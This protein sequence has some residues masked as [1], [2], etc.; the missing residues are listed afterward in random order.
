MLLPEPKF[1]PTVR[2]PMSLKCF[3]CGSVWCGGP[4]IP[5]CPGCGEGVP[6]WLRLW[7]RVAYRIPHKEEPWPTEEDF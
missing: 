4:A 1:Y 2:G 5:L 6:L 3:R 7:R